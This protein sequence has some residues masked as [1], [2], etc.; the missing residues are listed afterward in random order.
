MCTIIFGDGTPRNRFL[1]C[2]TFAYTAME[3]LGGGMPRIRL[4]PRAR[5]VEP[6]STPCEGL[7]AGEWPMSSTIIN[8]LLFVLAYVDLTYWGWAWLLHFL[9]DCSW[10]FR[11]WLLTCCCLLLCIWK[12]LREWERIWLCSH[13]DGW[14]SQGGALANPPQTYLG[15]LWP[16]D[17]IFLQNWSTF[18]DLWLSPHQWCNLKEEET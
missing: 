5:K 16:G 2:L 3:V 10:L 4:P 8:V 1:E 17:M 15:K 11:V 12:I 9:L 6:E 14:M 13:L 18:L 7:A